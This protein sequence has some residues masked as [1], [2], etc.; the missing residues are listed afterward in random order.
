VVNFDA[1]V[2]RGTISKR[3]LDL[4]HFSDTPDEAFA[5][6]KGELKKDL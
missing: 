4:L 1:L 6:L 5:F 3:D 2:R